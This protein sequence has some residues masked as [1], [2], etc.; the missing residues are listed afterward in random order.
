MYLFHNLLSAERII[1]NVLKRIFVILGT[2]VKNEV[3]NV[4]VIALV[5]I[6]VIR[7]DHDNTLFKTIPKCLW[8][9]NCFMTA[10]FT[11]TGTSIVFYVYASPCNN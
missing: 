9:S 5:N 4:H 11:N 1:L 6:P 8:L 10:L 7:S 3:V 2:A